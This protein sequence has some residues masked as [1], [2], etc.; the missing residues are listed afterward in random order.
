MADLSNSLADLAERVK[1]A[2][3]ASA[4]AERTGAEKALEAGGF[5]TQAKDQCKYGEW[6]PFLERAG[7]PERQ[8]QRLMQ[9]AR[10]GLNP[11]LVSDL[12]GI[13]ASLKWLASW[14]LPNP[15]ETLV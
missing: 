10:S 12:G 11:T 2:T 9:L 7:V 1:E 14:S 6:L 13:G 4:L 8:A 15:G 3:V 5:L